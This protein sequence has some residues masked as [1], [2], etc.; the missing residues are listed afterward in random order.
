MP[1]P[2]QAIKATNTTHHHHRRPQITKLRQLSH[3]DVSSNCLTALPDDLPPGLT[4]LDASNNSRVVLPESLSR[5]GALRALNLNW[6]WSDLRPVFAAG[7]G[8]TALRA[9]RAIGN[10][11]T[12]LPEG[13]GEFKTLR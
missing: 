10:G 7:R 2:P 12:E 11:I 4:H 13:I 6:V 8:L 5:L 9:L 1:C 3:L